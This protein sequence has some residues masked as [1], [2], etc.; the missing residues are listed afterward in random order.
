MN[1]ESLNKRIT[2][3]SKIDRT[4]PSI[5]L[6]RHDEH[7]DADTNEEMQVPMRAI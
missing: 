2:S 4:R 5:S 3:E 1:R 7:T 6:G